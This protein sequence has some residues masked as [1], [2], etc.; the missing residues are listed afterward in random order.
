MRAIS[1]AGVRTSSTSH[2]WHWFFCIDGL[3]KARSKA[4][5]ILIAE[6]LTPRLKNQRKLA[7]LVFKQPWR[8]CRKISAFVCGDE[9]KDFESYSIAIT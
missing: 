4:E 8:S 6:N 5:M 1:A 2:F 3:E 7:R 9:G